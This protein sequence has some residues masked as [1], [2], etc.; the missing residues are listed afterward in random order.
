MIYTIPII[1][2]AVIAL[3]WF[4]QSQYYNAIFNESHY[5]EIYDWL[6][7]MVNK[8]VVQNSSFGDKTVIVT[9]GKLTLVYTRTVEKDK[10]TIYVSVSKA[11]KH[12]TD[13]VGGRILY[14]VISAL[15]K[16]KA[17]ANIFKT[18][19]SVHH[20]ELSLE[21][22]GQNKIVTNDFGQVMKNMANYQPLAVP[23]IN[24]ERD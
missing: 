23:L 24:L 11:P 3:M 12:T 9:S 17:T 1:I 5:R 10:D 22:K 6:L 20:L 2:F 16:N 4:K 14:L 13:A 15:N 18:Q 7:E 19:T 8:G 21:E